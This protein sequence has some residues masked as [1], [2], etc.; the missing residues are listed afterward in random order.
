MAT[1]KLFKYSAQQIYYT[2]SQIRGY[3]TLEQ[4]NNG[5]G[6]LSCKISKNFSENSAISVLYFIEKPTTYE[7][8]GEFEL[9]EDGTTINPNQ[10]FSEV[11]GK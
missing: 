11:F 2:S 8:V 6:R 3:G 1:A 5:S 4:Y 9:L 7:F 10:D